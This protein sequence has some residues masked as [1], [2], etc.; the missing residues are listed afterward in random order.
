MI[1]AAPAF[2]PLS[3]LSPLSPDSARGWG[4][5]L[6]RPPAPPPPRG[7]GVDGV[8]SPYVFV[9]YAA[10]IVAFIFTPVM[11]RVAVHYGIVD[12]PDLVRK[13]H[14]TPVAYLGGIAVFLGWIAGL[15]VSQFGQ[16]HAPN[17][18]GLRHPVIPVTLVVG[19]FLI[20][21]L[22]LW[23]DVRGISPRLKVAGQVA[24]GSLLLWSGIGTELTGPFVSNAA[25]RLQLYA[26]F[27]VSE[28][29]I[30]WVTLATS[31][32]LAIG[33]IVFCCNASNLMDG[34]DG[35]CGG[36]TAIIVTGLL[37]LTVSLAA[38]E[39][40]GR[41]VDDALRLTIG[42]A[43]LAAVLAFVAFNFNPA[44]I[45]MGDAG[46]MFLGYLC[47][48]MILLIG[49]VEA[50]WLLGATVM[51]SLPVLD[52]ALAFARRYLAGRPFF[53]PDKFHFHH[54]L[55]ARGMSV[56]RAVLLSYALAV[57]FVGLGSA[58]VFIR[59]RYAVAVYLVIFGWIAVA[60]YKMGM[61]HERPL[62]LA[63]R[64]DEARDAADR[65][66]DAA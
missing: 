32:G 24:A 30:Y 19:A 28:A 17:P 22:G 47:G 2:S 50:K 9:F 46:S 27:G 52:T 11:R 51:F 10:F 34:L 33:V 48:A 64:D 44:S 12:K 41:I 66:A 55:V 58:I 23:D 59:T 20:V 56:R 43:M 8:L 14:R 45:F 3:P 42:I 57:V 6:L 54:Q 37:I 15:A 4:E 60:A 5:L 61:V 18:L 39:Q 31:G 21:L 63:A 16:I 25:A 53:S 7:L 49:K 36:V 1:S 29:T 65:A 35:L 26:G 40:Y 62:G 13:I 38:V